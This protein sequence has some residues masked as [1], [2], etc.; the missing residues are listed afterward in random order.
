MLNLKQISLVFAG[1]VAMSV[2]NSFASVAV[3]ATPVPASVNIAVEGNPI[4]NT[5]TGLFSSIPGVQTITFD[6][7]VNNQIQIP[8]NVSFKAQLSN[9]IFNIN[10]G[11]SGLSS[12]FSTSVPNIAAEPGV[13]NVSQETSNYLAVETGDDVTMSFTQ[14]VNY[15]GFHWGSVDSYNTVTFYNGSQQIGQFTGSQVPNAPANGNQTISP[16]N[17]FVDFFATS[18]Q[19]I[20]SVVFHNTTV[21]AFEIDNIAYGNVSVPEPSSMLGLVAL[22]VVGGGSVLKKRTKAL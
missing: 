1:T 10:S 13:T 6:N 7:L 8:T 5:S 19:N 14:P 18:G 3:F 11:N 4:V 17:P 12:V 21:P 9:N 20:T 15:L 2:A 16:N 22:G